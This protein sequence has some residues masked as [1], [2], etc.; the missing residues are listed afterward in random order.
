LFDLV[1][2]FAAPLQAEEAGE[3]L[4]NAADLLVFCEN[5]YAQFIQNELQFQ[6]TGLDEINKH[7]VIA[8]RLEQ[9]EPPLVAATVALLQWFE[10]LCDIAPDVLALRYDAA[11]AQGLPDFLSDYLPT[12]FQRIQNWATGRNLPELVE[13]SRAAASALT[14]GL[15]RLQL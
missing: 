4:G 2:A 11:G 13:R 8:F 1:I 3:A 6:I 9:R 10:H 7:K 5:F 14:A 12:L 15:A